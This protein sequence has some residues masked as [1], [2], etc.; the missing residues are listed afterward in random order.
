MSLTTS[1]VGALPVTSGIFG[2]PAAGGFGLIGAHFF[3]AGWVCDGD[4][5]LGVGVRL[6]AGFALDFEFE[7]AD[8]P[9]INPMT[10]PRTTSVPTVAPMTVLRFLA[11]ARR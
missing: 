10:A 7:P 2:C 11:R 3:G 4:D 8:S 1:L 5:E 9:T 6:A